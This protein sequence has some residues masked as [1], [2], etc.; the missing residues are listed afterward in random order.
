MRAALLVWAAWTGVALVFMLYIMLPSR[1]AQD[2]WEWLRATAWQLVSWWSWAVWTPLVVAVT[3]HAVSLRSSVRLLTVH[4]AAGVVVS[5][6]CTMLQGA[7]RWAVFRGVRIH[8]DIAGASSLPLADEWSFNL[9]VY[10]LVVGVFYAQRAGRLE[11]QLTQ[12]RLDALAARLRPHFLFNTL[13][14]ISALVLEDPQ[15]AN[16]M[17]ARL[18]EL[19]RQAFSRGDEAEVTLGEELRLLEHYVAIQEERFGDRLRVTVDVE[20]DAN[21]ALVPALLLQPLVENAVTHGLAGGE[22]HGAVT[23]RVEGSRQ[24]QRLRLVVRDDGPG[25][26]AGRGVERVGLA[27][28]RARLTDRYGSAQRLEVTDGPGGGVVVTIEIPF[29]TDAGSDR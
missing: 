11:A 6:L 28:T 29:A 2:P 26:G 10:G 17:I 3:R 25:F 9:V 19:L 18:A 22:R 27:G 15:A 4:L 12:A 21:Q 16:R 13:H 7:L 1:A 5:G 24:G 20:L 23:V 8:Y 14:T